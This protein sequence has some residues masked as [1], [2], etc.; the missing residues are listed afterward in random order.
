MLLFLMKNIKK[1]N[2][3]YMKIHFKKL[4]LLPLIHRD[5]IKLFIQF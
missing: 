2:Y 4:N 1:R 3:L 5:A